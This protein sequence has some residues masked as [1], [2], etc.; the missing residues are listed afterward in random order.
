MKPHRIFIATAIFLSY[1]T[2]VNVVHADA[3]NVINTLRTKECSGHLPTTR[4][5]KNS[6]KLSVAAK[7]VDNGLVIRE[8]LKRADYRADQSSVIHIG[9]S[10]DDAL[11][12]RMLAKSY[13]A[14]LTDAGLAE[15][16]IFATSHSIA[17]VFAAPFAPPSPGDA[18]QVAKQVLQLVNEARSKRRRCG[19]K[20]FKAVA[21]LTLNEQLRVA[22]MAHAKDMAKRG[23]VTHTGADGSSPG[24]RVTHAG[25]VWSNVGENVAGGQLSAAEV[26]AGWLA[27][28]GHCVNIMDADFTQMAVAYVIN[29]HQEIGIYWAQEFGRPR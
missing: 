13:C 20:E 18:P 9:G 19:N 7:H 16:G 14:T 27:S 1:F 28:P 24:D 15:V 2:A 21:P 5:L 17:M 12:K 3:L 11:L 23:V 10:I 29:S 6:S 8:A 25:Y 22:A 4:P 26:V